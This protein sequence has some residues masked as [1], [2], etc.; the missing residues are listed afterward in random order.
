[1]CH[2]GVGDT[3]A[4]NRGPIAVFIKRHTEAALRENTLPNQLTVVRFVMLAAHT[5]PQRTWPQ[6]AARDLSRGRL[7]FRAS[8]TKPATFIGH[9]FE[10]SNCDRHVERRLNI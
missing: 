8:A 4:Y 3:T 6:G 9:C 10:S 1:M 7:L 5:P 2:A